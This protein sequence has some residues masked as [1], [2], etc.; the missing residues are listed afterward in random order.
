M[1]PLQYLDSLIASQVA[2]GVKVQICELDFLRTLMTT[3]GKTPV[4][5]P[6]V[7]KARDSHHAEPQPEFYQ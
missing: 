6:E 3:Q 4:V 1:T 7:E 2:S 5:P